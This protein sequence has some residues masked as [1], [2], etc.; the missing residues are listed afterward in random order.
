MI[1]LGSHGRMVGIKCPASQ[2]VEAE[3]RYTFDRTLEGKRVGQVRPL[4]RRSWSLRTSDAT[5]PADVSA[6]TAFVNGD[7]GS[8]PFWFV[9]ADAPHVNLLTPAGSACR[10]LQTGSPNI[11]LDGPVDLGAAGWSA[12]SIRSDDPFATSGNGA[13]IYMGLDVIPVLP[14]VSVTASAWV[15]G[16]GSRV[17][18]Y[19]YDDTFGTPIGGVTG[20]VEGTAAWSR[21]H[22]TGTPPANAVGC[23]MIALNAERA[24]RPAVTWTS[25]LEGWGDGQGCPKAVVHGAA[26]SLTLTGMNGT[27]SNVSYTIT[28]VG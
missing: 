14:G 2:D 18:I 7:W 15:K 8:G 9:S 27:Y 22:V 3:D 25:A 26:R 10:E 6:V 19:W 17:R 24:T 28:E 12:R 23:R 4:G 5:T 11:K 1:Y 20:V 13:E 16:A 21:V